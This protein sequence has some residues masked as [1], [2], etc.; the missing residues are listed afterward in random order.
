MAI[1]HWASNHFARQVHFV[2]HIG[3]AN[4]GASKEFARQVHLVIKPYIASKW[5]GEQTI[6]LALSVLVTHLSRLDFRNWIAI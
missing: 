4:H 3:R 6:L 2:N 1:K 5:D